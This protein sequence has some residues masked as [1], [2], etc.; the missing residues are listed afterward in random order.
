MH[1]RE[2]AQPHYY[3]ND[4]LLLP[5]ALDEYVRTVIDISV[6]FFQNWSSE[7]LVPNLPLGR[8]LLY[9]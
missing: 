3:I 2:V 9:R 1:E 6:I 5:K 7:R 4:S 8:V